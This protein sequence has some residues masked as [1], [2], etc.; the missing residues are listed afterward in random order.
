MISSKMDNATVANK[1]IK[2]RKK[3]GLALGGGAS[4]G[5]AHVGVI[6]ALEKHNIPIDYIAGT[7]MGSLVGGWYALNKNVESIYPLLDE[8]RQNSDSLMNEFVRKPGSMSKKSSFNIFKKYIDGR[9]FEDCKIPFAAV[10]C[11]LKTGHEVVMDSGD[12]YSAMEASAAIPIVFPTVVRDGKQLIDGG[13]VNPVPANVV[14]Q[15]GADVVIAVDVSSHWFDIQTFSA[16]GLKWR[17]IHHVFEAMFSVMSHQIAMDIEKNY[18]DIVIRPPVL[19]YRW[20]DFKTP[21][22][23]VHYGETETLN[24]IDQILKL[25]GKRA[26]KK[27]VSENFWDFLFGVDNNNEE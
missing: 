18:A 12:I 13:V 9:T 19:H 27:G 5:L 11:D 14:R 26:R 24:N 2:G 25:A 15:M 23:I 4:K 17:N 16:E 20:F 10:A 22:E 1:K 3:I 7:S 21:A 8:V 6:K